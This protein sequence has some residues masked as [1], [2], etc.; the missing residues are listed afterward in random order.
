VVNDPNGNF[1]IL[2]SWPSLTRHTQGYP[3]GLQCNTNRYIT[4]GSAELM[5]ELNR[6]FGDLALRSVRLFP[7]QILWLIFGSAKKN[8]VREKG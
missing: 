2:I 6:Y 3:L 4:G 7:E 5:L 1:E 8:S